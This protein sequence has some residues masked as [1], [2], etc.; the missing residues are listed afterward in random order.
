LRWRWLATALIYGLL[1]AGGYWWLREAWQPQWA[2]WWLGWAG[3]VMLLELTVLWLVLPNNHPPETE[4]LR[5]TFGY[6]TA[7]TLACGLMLFLLAGFLFAPRPPGLLAWLPALLYTVARLVDYVDGYVARITHHETKLGGILDME[8]DGFGVLI[9]ILLGIQYGALPLWYLP[10]ALSRQLFILGIW[11]RERRGLPVYAMTPSGNRRIVAGY[12]TAFLSWALWPSF[13]PPLSLLAA[14]VFAVPLIASFSRDWLVVSGVLD[15]AT[16]RYQRGR[17]IVKDY[18][19]GWLPLLARLLC[20]GIG[21][22][23]LWVEVP[24]FPTWLPFLQHAGW[25]S[26]L[27]WLWLLVILSAT[28]L[29]AILLGVVGRVAA[30]PL[31]A[32]AWLDVAANGLAWSDNALLFVA[33]AIVTH[34][35]SGHFALWQPEEA[36]LHTRPGIKHVA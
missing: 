33:A 19:E 9:A 36:L 6:G 20:F 1:L 28:S 12:Q 22:M 13:Q 10:L 35:G 7:L 34:A 21:V 3:F 24:D 30:L 25:T 8:L 16:T 2:K 27:L 4:T 15:A 14:T 17:I 18:L 26:P 5:P 23:L 31:L 11:L 29:V 32:L